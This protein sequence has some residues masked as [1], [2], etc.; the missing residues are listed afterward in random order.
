MPQICPLKKEEEEKQSQINQVHCTGTVYSL[1]F[2][3]PMRMSLT[4]SIL[5]VCASTWSGSKVLGAR[6][7][8]RA[9]HS[10]TRGG[11]EEESDPLDFCLCSKMRER[12]RNPGITVS[13]RLDMMLNSSQRNIQILKGEQGVPDNG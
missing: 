6:L 3:T 10:T 11:A 12:G 4:S 2:S 1:P 8:G 13:L 5:F 7:L 9:Y